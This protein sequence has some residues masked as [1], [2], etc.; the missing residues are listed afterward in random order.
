MSTSWVCRIQ[1]M[2]ENVEKFQFTLYANNDI[3]VRIKKLN[4][5]NEKKLIKNLKT[6]YSFNRLNTVFLQ[7]KKVII[8]TYL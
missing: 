5:N 7:N 6:T 1:I 4:I 2:P 3:N 8:D